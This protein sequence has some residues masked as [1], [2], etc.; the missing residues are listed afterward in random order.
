[1]SGEFVAAMEDVLALYALP[2]DA[3][4]P[5]VCL[6]EKPVVLHADVRPGLPLAPGHVECRD[7][8]YERHATANL[9]VLVEP[10]AGWRHVSVTERRTKR[11]YAEGLRYLVE[12]RYPEAECICVVQD[13]LNTHSAGA[14]YEAFPPQQARRIL[15]RLEFHYTPKHGSWLNQTEIEISSFERGCRSRPVGDTGALEQRVRA[16]ELER[17]ARRATVDWQFTNKQARVKLK[18]LYP[19]VNAQPD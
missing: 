8:E 9:F 13:N 16:L 1:M 12:E 3:R 11:D 18:R 10:L 15:S 4:Y 19:T 14:L 2:Y 7:Y 17:N 6:D 5:T